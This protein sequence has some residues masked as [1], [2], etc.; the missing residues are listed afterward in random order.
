MQQ[1][2]PWLCALLSYT[3]VQQS[4]WGEETGHAHEADHIRGAQPPAG[5]FPEWGGLI[6]RES[7]LL[8]FMC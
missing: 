1:M 2:C 6:A 3:A 8:T 4:T 7:A 5:Q